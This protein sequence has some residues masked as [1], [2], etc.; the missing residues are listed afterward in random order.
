MVYA[1]SRQ[2]PHQASPRCQP[3]GPGASYQLAQGPVAVNS[4]AQGFEGPTG[5]LRGGCRPVLYSL[6]GAPRWT[7]SSPQRQFWS[8][9]L[10]LLPRGSGSLRHPP[11][12]EMSVAEKQG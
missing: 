8:T 9:H 11:T 5:V 7:S 1:R 10:L 6:T 2:D 3:Q 4:P 12:S